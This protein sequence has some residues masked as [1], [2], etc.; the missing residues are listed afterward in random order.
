MELKK[1]AKCG[2]ELH[3]EANFC[4]YCESLQ[5]P[6]VE[7]GTPHV[8]RWKKFVPAAVAMLAVIVVC[9]AVYAARSSL[10]DYERS[11]AEAVP[12]EPSETA[13]AVSTINSGTPVE[14]TE[15]PAESS[16]P[17][18]EGVIVDHKT[19]D[20]RYEDIHLVFS[21]DQQNPENIRVWDK[22][23]FRAKQGEEYQ[24]PVQLYAYSLDDKQLAND[25]FNELFQNASISVS[26]EN[27]DDSI[28]FSMLH[29]DPANENAALTSDI[30]FGLQ[31]F[32]K[33]TVTL[34]LNMKNGDVVRLHQILRVDRVDTTAYYPEDVPMETLEELQAL[35]TRLSREAGK[36]EI[37]DLHLPAVT[38]EG[39]LSI[40]GKAFNLYGSYDGNAQTT[41][42]GTVSIRTKEPDD[43]E[44]H[45]IRFEGTGIGLEISQPAH[46][47]N[48]IFTGLKT[49]ISVK[50]GA[51]PDVA[52]CLFDANGTGILF[53]SRY[54]DL[55]NP[56][57]PENVFRDNN[58][59]IRL[60]SV[61]NNIP[62]SFEGCV[63]ADN[64]TDIQNNCGNKYDDS[65]A[66]F[67]E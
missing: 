67:K 8:R 12:A 42:T 28:T 60:V 21:F 31:N 7:S 53:D 29:Y 39:G 59:G 20:V 51:W 41:F 48:C 58:V 6:L 2:R 33:N 66:E 44:L 35:M 15:L 52:K 65:G 10:Y 54:S 19:P 5:V 27:G 45:N 14:E 61:P 30:R 63:F 55:H 64:G 11:I 17:V 9:G 22:R 46:F 36:K 25:R 37:I 1:C 26:S 43:C 57:L 62:L 13:E 23:D 34:T 47:R 32:G 4:P 16:E 49:G 50:D 3:P 18:S 40:S 24:L 56:T 38:Y